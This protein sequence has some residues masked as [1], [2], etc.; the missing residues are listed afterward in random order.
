MRIDVQLE[1]VQ[2]TRTQQN[3]FSPIRSHTFSFRLFQIKFLK[4]EI[5]QPIIHW[6]V[7]QYGATLNNWNI[8]TT[9]SVKFNGCITWFRLR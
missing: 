7:S 1:I 3:L 4:M 6:A 8:Y 5:T 9:I 2:I